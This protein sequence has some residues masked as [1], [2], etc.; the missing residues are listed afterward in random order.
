MLIFYLK[1]F[2][3]QVKSDTKYIILYRFFY[4]NIYKI[5]IRHKVREELLNIRR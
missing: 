4:I 5:N 1:N 2:D 3:M